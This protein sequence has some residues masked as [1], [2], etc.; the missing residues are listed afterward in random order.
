MCGPPGPSHDLTPHCSTAGFRSGNREG[1]GSPGVGWGPLAWERRPGQRP[2]PLGTLGGAVRMLAS[3]ARPWP[4]LSPRAAAR[5]LLFLHRCNYLFPASALAPGAPRA[6]PEGLRSGALPPVSR[7]SA[8]PPPK[9]CARARARRPQRG[10]F[11][12]QGSPRPAAALRAL[13]ATSTTPSPL[14]PSSAAP[15]STEAP[16]VPVLGP[17]PPSQLSD[18][19]PPLPAWRLQKVP[20]ASVPSQLC[21]LQAAPRSPTCLSALKLGSEP[22]EELGGSAGGRGPRQE[23]QA[24]PHVGNSP[25]QPPGRPPGHG[26]LQPPGYGV[27][28]PAPCPGD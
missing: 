7:S 8:G 23:G 21:P 4:W 9:P 11:P 15:V 20:Q 10:P 3:A 5:D 12:E 27:S 26:P 22:W 18:L 24:R 19:L 14:F 25:F 17:A 2:R 6:Q 28:R 16:M 13:A 1:G